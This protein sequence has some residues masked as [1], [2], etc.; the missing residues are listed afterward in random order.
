MAIEALKVARGSR[1]LGDI[2]RA[3]RA[4]GDDACESSHVWQMENGSVCAGPRFLRY[5]RALGM[6][7]DALAAIY[8]EHKRAEK[9]ATEA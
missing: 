8:E 1:S 9:S 3:M 6:E 2:A 4:M 7:P 5:A